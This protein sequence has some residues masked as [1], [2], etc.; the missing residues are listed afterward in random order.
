MNDKVRSRQDFVFARGRFAQAILASFWSARHLS[1]R[2]LSSDPSVAYSAAASRTASR[3]IRSAMRGSGVYS[4]GAFTRILR[5]LV[6][7]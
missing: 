1:A 7:S 6:M 4:M 5:I 2:M 3:Q